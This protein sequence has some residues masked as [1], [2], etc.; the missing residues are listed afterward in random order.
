MKT[1]DDPHESPR[2]SPLA[3]SGQER[4]QSILY[5]PKEALAT[6]ET[7]ETPD[8]FHDLNLDQIVAGITAGREEY[9]LKPFFHAPLT[10][11]DAV[12]YRQEVGRDLE[13][14]LLMRAGEAFSGQMRRVRQY[15]DKAKN[16]YYE[17]ER[18]RWFLDSACL[19]GEAVQRLHG[20][21]ESADLRS[22]GLRGFR[23]HLT[24]YLGSSA[25]LRPVDEARRIRDALSAIRYCL[26]IRDG[27]VTVRPY[28]DEPDYSIPVAE[29]FEKFRRG[30]GKDFLV[31][32]PERTGM[33]HIMAQIVERVAL[34]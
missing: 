17:H 23:D 9:D 29:S 13:D 30:A 14:D 21:L 32:F 3:E 25:F 18:Q 28:H 1:F 33:N 19:Y 2:P 20:E 8:S 11:L 7:L 31:Q 4:F 10:N 24:E 34:L 6:P 26:Q 16:G 12:A 27:S 15:L 22:R 5:P